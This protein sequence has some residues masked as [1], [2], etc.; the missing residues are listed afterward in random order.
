MFFNRWYF[1]KPKPRI[2]RYKTINVP[3]ITLPTQDNVKQLKQL[4]SGFKWTTNWNKYQSKLTQ[5]TLN[6]NLYFLIDPS[7]Q[8]INKLIVFNS[9]MVGFEKV[10][11]NVFLQ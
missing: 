11:C 8:G 1:R 2:C 7:F 6:R 3:V 4:E 10:T 5:Q 9:K